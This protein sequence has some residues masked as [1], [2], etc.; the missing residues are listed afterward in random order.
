LLAPASGGTAET[1]PR[2]GIFFYSW[3]GTPAHDG[4]YAH[5]TQAGHAAPNDIASSFYPRRGA[6]SSSDRSLLTT[7]VAEIRAAGVDELIVT[8]WGRGS[9][10]DARLPAIV[11]AAAVRGLSVAAHLEPYP[12]RSV[13]SVGEDLDYLRRLGIVD[14]Y[15]YRP[16]DLPVSDW[17]A[18]D[19]GG[20]RLFAETSLVGRARDA[21]FDGVYTY[22]VLARGAGMF[23]R[24]CEQARRAELLCAPS[25]GPGYDARRA[26]LDA[27]LKPRRNGTTY[28]SMWSAAVRA[29]ADLVTI[30][31]YN[32]WHEGTQIEPAR[33]RAGYECYDGAWGLHGERAA[34]A[35]LD[36]TAYWAGIFR[37]SAQQPST[38]AS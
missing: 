10:E 13:A 4:T 28:D 21:R 35:Y 37:T 19:H 20:T 11:G 27:R 32:E 9:A 5:W 36:R 24:L 38:S 26:G 3:Y 14:V 30:T 17:A 7:Q 8:W 2:V 12:N 22:D 29:R 25:V 15:V 33:R 31:S 23:S 18:L 34:R 16:F 6:Y 1:T